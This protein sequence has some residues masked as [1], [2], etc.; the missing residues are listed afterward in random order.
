[1]LPTLLFLGEFALILGVAKHSLC[2]KGEV[3]SAALLNV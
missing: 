3:K 1:M 2:E